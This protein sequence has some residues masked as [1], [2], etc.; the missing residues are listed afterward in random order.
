MRDCTV[1]GPELGLGKTKSMNYC[2]SLT[3]LLRLP[4]CLILRKISQEIHRPVAFSDEIRDQ[5][6]Y[7]G[8]N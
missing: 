7:G 2:L 8:P 4:D 6:Q 1:W 5:V 3:S